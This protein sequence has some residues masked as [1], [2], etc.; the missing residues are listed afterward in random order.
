E[1]GVSL[2]PLVPVARDREL[3]LS[4]A[5]QRLWFLDQLEPASPAYNIPLAVG[6]DGGASA[7]LLRRVFNEVIRRHEVLRTRFAA[8]GGEPRQVIAPALELLLPV[9]DLRSLPEAVRAVEARRLAAAEARRPF[10]LATGPLLRV[11]L[12]RLAEE[13]VLL[14][15]MHHIVSDGWSMGIFRRELTAISEAF[16]Q[17]LPSPLAELPVQYADFACWQRQWL[18]DEVLETQLDYW[19]KQLAGFPRRGTN[20]GFPRRGTN[21]GSPGGG[22]MGGSPRRLPAAVTAAS[23]TSSGSS[24]SRRKRSRPWERR[25][26]VRKFSTR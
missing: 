21:G 7:A 13:Q 6:L 19:R 1:Q 12:L 26:K 2:P 15:T 14:L 11:T 16:S 8:V 17:G 18:R 9:V 22:Q 23:A 4:F 10:D 3:P 24:S 25:E 20:G 5:Q